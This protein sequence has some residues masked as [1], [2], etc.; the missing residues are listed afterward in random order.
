MDWFERAAWS[1]STAD[2]KLTLADAHGL[3]IM[4]TRRSAV[5]WSTDRH[6]GL[7]GVAFGLDLAHF[8]G[9]DGLAY[10]ALG[11]FGDVDSG[12]R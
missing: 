1:R 9:A 12:V 3:A 7:G 11:V 5:C 10:V 8:G 2:Q 6:L 4:Q